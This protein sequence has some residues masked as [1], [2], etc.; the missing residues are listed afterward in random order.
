[1]TWRRFM[2]LL[3]G[4]SVNSATI[5]ALRIGRVAPSQRV[6]VM[7]TPAQAQRAFESLFGKSKR[8]VDRGDH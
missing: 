6:S 8:K 1:M 5:T 3:R 2:V 7:S 4:L